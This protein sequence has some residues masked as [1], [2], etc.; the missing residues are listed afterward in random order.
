MKAVP[1]IAALVG[2]AVIAVLIAVFG[3]GAVLSSLTPSGG[4]DL[5]RFA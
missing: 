5:R 3:V 2:L 1:V 4:E